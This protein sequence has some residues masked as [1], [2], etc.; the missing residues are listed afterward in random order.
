MAPQRENV[1]MYGS[2]F[3]RI[4]KRVHVVLYSMYMHFNTNGATS[5]ISFPSVTSKY[6]I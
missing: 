3:W 4:F 6:L 1:V 5:R 2:Y